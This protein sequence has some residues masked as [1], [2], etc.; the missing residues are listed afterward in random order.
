MVPEVFRFLF[1]I[2]RHL[3]SRTLSCPLLPT[4]NWRSPLNVTTRAFSTC[5]MSPTETVS[6]CLFHKG[7]WIVPVSSA[8]LVFVTVANPPNR[9]MTDLGL[10]ISRTLAFKLIRFIPDF[11][12]PIR[13]CFTLALWSIVLLEALAYANSLRGL[14]SSRMCLGMGNWATTLKPFV[15]RKT[16]LSRVLLRHS[17]KRLLHLD[18]WCFQ[19]STKLSK[20]SFESIPYFPEIIARYSRSLISVYERYPPRGRPRPLDIF[21]RT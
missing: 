16:A 17:I 15:M 7:S 13:R 1:K 5:I 8:M 2:T 19:V 11:K 18:S 10:G 6:I 9:V 21:F 3:F 14:T 20:K 4:L 12:S